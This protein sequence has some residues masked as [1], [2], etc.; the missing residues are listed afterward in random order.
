M[1]EQLHCRAFEELEGPCTLRAFFV[2]AL[3]T[4]HTW[5]LGFLMIE[6]LPSHFHKCKTLKRR[7]G[8]VQA[9]AVGGSVDCDGQVCKASGDKSVFSHT[10]TI[11]ILVF[12]LPTDSN[13]SIRLFLVQKNF[14]GAF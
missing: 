10:A 4:E 5:H 1:S 2:C 12:T 6:K 14:S 7:V 8:T 11:P 13:R 9:A 3:S